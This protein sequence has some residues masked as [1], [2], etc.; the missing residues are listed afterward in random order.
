MRKQILYYAIT[1]GGEWN[2]IKLALEQ[3]EP[4]KDVNYQ[5][6]FVTIVDADYPI[7]FRR[8][9]NPPWILFYEGNLAY[10][11]ASSVGIVGS[12]LCSDYGKE[13]CEL[14]ISKIKL[15]HVIVSGLAKGIDAYAHQAAIDQRTIGIIGC[16]LD[17]VYPKCNAWLYEYMRKHHLILSEYPNGVKPL[18]YHFPWRNRLIA[19]LSDA[20]IVIE[21][22]RKSGSMLTVNE[23]IE[24]DIPVYCVPHAFGKEQGEGCNLLISQ[25]ANILVDEEDIRHIF[26]K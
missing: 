5:G 20:V 7:R 10:C 15:D 19:A 23:A 4:W 11:D 18:A 3:E 16:G 25:G 14:V 13:M 17:I 26:H 12:R 21:A 24:L 8:L 6:S 22:T 1:Y 9:Q 2:K